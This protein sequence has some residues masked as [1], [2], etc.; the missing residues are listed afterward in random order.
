MESSELEFKV[1]EKTCLTSCVPAAGTGA[2]SHLRNGVGNLR[3][4][5]IFRGAVEEE[6]HGGFQEERPGN[7][8]IQRFKT[9]G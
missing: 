6:Q 8:R 2:R 7:T 9:I 3:L 5:P 4:S 1:P